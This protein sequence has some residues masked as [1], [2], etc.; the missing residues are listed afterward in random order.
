MKAIQ[1]ALNAFL[2]RLAGESVSMSDNTTVVTYLK[3]EGDISKM[4]C[5][6]A[7]ETVP[8]SDSLGSN[9]SEIY[10]REKEYPGGS[11]ELPRPGPSNGVVTSSLG[12]R[13]DLQGLQ[14]PSYQCNCF[15]SKCQTTFMCVSIARSHGVETGRL[16][17]PV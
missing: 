10:P 15:Q 11:V 1:S 4:M 14:F 5:D 17:I 8:W 6:L 3:K 2:D 12:I 7:R 13:R 16:P 9:L